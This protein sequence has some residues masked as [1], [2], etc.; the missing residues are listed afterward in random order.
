MGRLGELTIRSIPEEL[1]K[2]TGFIGTCGARVGLRNREILD[3]QISADEACSNA[4]AYAYPGTTGQIRVV[5]E[6]TAGWFSITVTDDGVPFD[7]LAAPEP[8]LDASL[9][10]TSLGG[11]GIHLIR[12]LMDEVTYERRGTQNVLTMRKK[13]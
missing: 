1:E 11:L 5:C 4:I 7:P 13:V 2:V 9:D 6:T 3:S 12:T 8:D 10:S